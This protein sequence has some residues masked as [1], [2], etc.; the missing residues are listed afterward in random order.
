MRQ[1]NDKEINK[2]FSLL[3]FINNKSAQHSLFSPFLFV[4][5]LVPDDFYLITP[6]CEPDLIKSVPYIFI[7]GT[8]KWNYGPM[9]NISIEAFHISIF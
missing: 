9:E 3:H 8:P 5:Y 4:G 2:L 6:C 1:P 7:E